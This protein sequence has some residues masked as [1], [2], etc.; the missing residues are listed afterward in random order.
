MFFNCYRCY[1]RTFHHCL[2]HYPCIDSGNRLSCFKHAAF[3]P[4]IPTVL[5]ENKDSIEFKLLEQTCHPPSPFLISYANCVTQGFAVQGSEYSAGKAT[6]QVPAVIRAKFALT[7]KYELHTLWNTCCQRGK[8][9]Q[10]T[11]VSCVGDSQGTYPEAAMQVFQK[12]KNKLE[13]EEKP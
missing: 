3:I 7:W 11:A 10:G 13:R 9:L 5:H 1:F 12:N 2:L 6:W 4:F 8:N